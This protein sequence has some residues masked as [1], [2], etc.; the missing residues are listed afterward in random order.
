M[1]QEPVRKVNRAKTFF[2]QIQVLKLKRE[3]EEPGFMH[4]RV[5][6]LKVILYLRPYHSYTYLVCSPHLIDSL[7]G[8]IYLSDNHL[9]ESVSPLLFLLLLLLHHHSLLLLY[10]C[11]DRGYNPHCSQLARQLLYEYIASIDKLNGS[12]LDE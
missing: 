2:L 9:F 1:Y 5:L 11:V 4:L 12:I 6:L 10:L 8:F 7:F 3:I